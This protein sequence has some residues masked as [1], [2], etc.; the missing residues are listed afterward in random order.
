[1]PVTNSSHDT[2]MP[3]LSLDDSDTGTPQSTADAPTSASGGGGGDGGNSDTDGQDEPEKFHASRT[4]INHVMLSGE[5]VLSSNA[6]TDQ[7]FSKGKSVHN[8]GIRSALCVPI[9]MRRLELRPAK[10]RRRRGNRR[11]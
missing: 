4:I 5:G 1:M 9:K 10:A 11:A 6:M 3:V 2:R 8:M 7:R